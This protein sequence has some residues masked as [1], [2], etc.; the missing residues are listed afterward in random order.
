MSLLGSIAAPLI[1]GGFD[2]LGGLLGKGD[3]PRMQEARSYRLSKRLADLQFNQNLSMYR[4]ARSDDAKKVRTLVA[5]SKAAGIH[6]IAA[7]GANLSSPS[8]MPISVGQASVSGSSGRESMANAL[9]NIGARVGDAIANA[10]SENTQLQNELLRAQIRSVNADAAS[11]LSAAVSRTR[12]S[13]IM[14]ASIGGPGGARTMDSAAGQ[15]NDRSPLRTYGSGEFY[16]N[17][18]SEPAST[19]E[20]EYGEIAGDVMGLWQLANDM[21]A[22]RMRGK[23]QMQP[24]TRKR[25]YKQP[26]GYKGRQFKRSNFGR[27]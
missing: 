15:R 20:N 21:W 26:S 9:G 7:L 12:A 3:S 2:L 17:K 14:A 8:A 4:L 5:D 13:K 19:W 22:T 23:A 24:R 6:P 27:M 11:S 18:H 16:P 1:S 10:N 25:P